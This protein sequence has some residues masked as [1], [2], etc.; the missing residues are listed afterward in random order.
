MAKMMHKDINDINIH[1]CK[2]HIHTN[3]CQV[4]M[5]FLRYTSIHQ[6]CARHTHAFIHACVPSSTCIC[7]S[8]YRHNEHNMNMLSTN[9]CT[10]QCGHLEASLIG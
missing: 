9:E 4:N 6:Y 7:M 8:G 5:Y 3:T 2:R 1:R 10:T